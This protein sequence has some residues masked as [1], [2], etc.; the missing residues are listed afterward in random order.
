M[1]YVLRFEHLKED[2]KE[3]VEILQLPEP[4]ELT[5]G[6][7]PKDGYYQFPEAY[8]FQQSSVPLDYSKY[9]NEESREY[10]AE[11]LEKDIIL[12][13]EALEKDLSSEIQK[14]EVEIQEFRAKAPERINKIAIQTSV[15]LLQQLI[16]TDVNSSSIST[17]VNDLSSK[18]MDK[19][20]G[21]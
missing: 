8:G 19:Y 5:W 13:K 1:D 6:G 15:D 3:V 4:H 7:H 11:R 16:G 9:Y 21:N 20:Y 14:A 2:W 10:V 12:K 17:I 18:K